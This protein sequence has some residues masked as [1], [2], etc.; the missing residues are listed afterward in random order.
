MTKRMTLR[1]MNMSKKR[2]KKSQKSHQVEILK[3]EGPWG[4]KQLPK[5]NNQGWK[6]FKKENE[7]TA[8]ET[9]ASTTTEPPR[10]RS[11]NARLIRE[12][13]RLE[14]FYNQ[15]A[16]KVVEE[17]KE[18]Q[19]KLNLLLDRE[20]E[21]GNAALEK[22]IDDLNKEFALLMADKLLEERNNLFEDSPETNRY[23]VPKDSTN[24]RLMEI[25]EH[26]TESKTIYPAER[27]GW[28]KNV[29]PRLKERLPENFRGAWEHENDKMKQ[30][31]RKGMK[32]EFHDMIVRGVWRNM[33]RRDLP[34]GR[35]CIKCKW[36]FDIKRNGIF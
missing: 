23:H 34:Q 2:R 14:S 21:F 3:L 22:E 25:L 5:N 29:V 10:P 28:L 11:E 26:A 6:P 8:T 27:E 35:Q 31:W 19:E 17:T 32:K 1:L 16:K 33:K 12:L 4:P 20:I 9:T 7:E 30:R 15:D 13:A 18:Q 36:V 24:E